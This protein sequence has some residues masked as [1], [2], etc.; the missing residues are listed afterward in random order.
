MGVAHQGGVPHLWCVEVSGVVILLL[1][2][3]GNGGA[4]LPIHEGLDYRA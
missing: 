1:L 4:G 3:D 2:V